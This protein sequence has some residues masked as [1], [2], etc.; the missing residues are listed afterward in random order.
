[1]IRFDLICIYF[2]IY[3]DAAIRRFRVFLR[4]IR[5]RAVHLGTHL[6]WGN[7]AIL[8]CLSEVEGCVAV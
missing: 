3:A 2:A 1:M 6:P 7:H 4:W 5:R 8:H